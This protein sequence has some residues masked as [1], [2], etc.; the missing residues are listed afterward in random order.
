MPSCEKCWAESGND[1]I[2]YGKLL[3]GN[4]CTLEE[5]AGGDRA[6]ECSECHEKTVHI[7]TKYCLACGLD[8]RNK[9]S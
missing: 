3:D 1:I 8:N 6:I 7:H 5:Q 9:E 4:D 2:K